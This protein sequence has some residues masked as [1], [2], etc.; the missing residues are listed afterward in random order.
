MNKKI[1]KWGLC[2]L[3]GLFTAAAF[4]LEWTGYDI[5]KAPSANNILNHIDPTCRHL[6]NG[7]IELARTIFGSC[8]DYDKVKIFNRPH[9]LVLTGAKAMAPNG[10]IY[11]AEPNL[12]TP[13]FSKGNILMQALFLHEMTHVWQHQKGLNVRKEAFLEWTKN[14]F[15]YCKAYNVAAETNLTETSRDKENLHFLKTMNDFG[16]LNIEQQAT[17]IENYYLNLYTLNSWADQ[18]GSTRRQTPVLTPLRQALQNYKDQLT[19]TEQKS[20]SYLPIKPHTVQV[21]DNPVAGF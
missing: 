21:P 6:T 11:V 17:I 13:D 1:K 3:V 19:L 16:A 15:D 14:G 8:I 2:A 10:H 4:S 20:Q 5:V 9:F 18:S 12:R 7:E